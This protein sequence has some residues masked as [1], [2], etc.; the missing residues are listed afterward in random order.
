MQ[1]DVIYIDVEDDITAI[2]GKVKDAKE[3][4]VALVPPKRVGV[5]QSAVN[6]RLLMRAATQADK[7]VVLI[8]NNQALLALAGSAKLPVAKNLQSKPE[9]PEIAALKVDDDD[10]IIDGEQLPVGEHASMAK[11][12]DVSDA[13]LDGVSIDDEAA[14]PVKKAAPPA[15]GATPA[16]PRAKS[17]VKVPSFDT[18]RKKFIFIIAGSIALIGFLVWAIVFAPHAKVVIDAQ[19]SPQQ[20]K[21]SVMLGASLA[22][23]AAKGTLTSTTQQEKQPASVDFTATGKKDVGEKA[24]GTVKFSTDSFSL[25]M[26]GKS[27]PLGT[28][29]TASN[30]MVYTTTQ[31]ATFS[32][33]NSGQVT[34]NITAVDIGEG[35]NGASGSVTGAPSGVS[36]TIETSPSGGSKKTIAVVTQQDVMTA[37]GQ[38]AKQKADDIKKKLADKFPASSIVIDS[39]FVT[40]AGE[41]QASPAIGQEA[42]D[43]K[44]KVSQ[45]TTYALSAVDKN[46]LDAFLTKALQKALTDTKE[47][48]VYETGIKDA[49]L[50]DF[51]KVDDAGVARVNL[52]ATGRVGPMINDE[53]IK[54]QIKGKRFGEVQSMLKSIDGVRDAVTTF[55]PF[56]VQTVPSDSKKITIE[57]KLSDG[58]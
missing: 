41:A 25:I 16:R 57:F 2:I 53:D 58:K 26:G 12:D 10:D 13:V 6:L 40:T 14:P 55:S 35:Y 46:D 44:A 9:V 27:V 23:D 54:N 28:Q 15:A 47:Q 45:E 34:V 21:T 31:T 24:T 37:T 22:T 5:L 20:V 51:A 33:A 42:P 11:N 29:L 1:K 17:G 52:S 50:A 49:Q 39:S 4:V 7:R 48:R 3:K 38:L 18:F 8:T 56:W 30:G 43:G 36:A 32:P 19:T